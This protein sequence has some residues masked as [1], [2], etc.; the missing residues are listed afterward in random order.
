MTTRIV[1]VRVKYIRNADDGWICEKVKP[2]LKDWMDD[3][4]NVYIG[5][6]GCILIDKRRF[7]E[8]NSEYANPYKVGKDGTLDEVLEKYEIYLRKKLEDDTF[9]VSFLTLKGKRLGCWC[10]PNKCHG[11]IILKILDTI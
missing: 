7:P 4:E 6:R 3:D 8:K 9:K 1:N 11:D 5:R 10:K 2:T